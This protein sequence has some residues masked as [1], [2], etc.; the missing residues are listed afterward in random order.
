MGDRDYILFVGL[1]LGILE[2]WEL[3][4]SI[5]IVYK[6]DG[7]E[8]ANSYFISGLCSLVPYLWTLFLIL[9]LKPTSG[10]SVVWCAQVPIRVDF[11]EDKPLAA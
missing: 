6:G 2:K 4:S 3:L 1:D 7:K 5:G 8:H 10:A 9:Q 11:A